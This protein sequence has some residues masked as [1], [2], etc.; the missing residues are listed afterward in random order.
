MK[1]TEIIR[2]GIR[3]WKISYKGIPGKRFIVTEEKL[4]SLYN[5]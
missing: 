3:L 2:N 4:L 5:L 1:A